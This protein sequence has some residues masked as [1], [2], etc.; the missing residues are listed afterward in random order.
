[1]K[2]CFYLGLSFDTLEANTISNYSRDYTTEPATQTDYASVFGVLF[3]GVTGILAGANM[4]GEL[5]DPGRN[6]PI[7]TLSAVLFTLIVYVTLS[8]FSAASCSRFLLQNHFLFMLSVNFWPL[9]V[10]VGVITATLSASLS[11][12]IGSSRVLEALAKDKIFGSVF[13]WILR[14]K[15]GSNPVGAV[16]FSW[17]LVQII[18]LIGKFYVINL[19]CMISGVECRNSA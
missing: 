19:I 11:N 2:T 12:L 4:S 7:G 15:W 5:K 18:L 13:D 3:S 17:F 14:L 10:A 16:F 8:I 9:L 6:I 1:M